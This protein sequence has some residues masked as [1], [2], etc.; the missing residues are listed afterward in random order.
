MIVYQQDYGDRRLW[1]RPKAMFM[2]TVPYEGKEVPRFQY[3]GE[4]DE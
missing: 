4:V 1:V 2:E 3:L